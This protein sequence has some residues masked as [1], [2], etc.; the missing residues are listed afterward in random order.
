M[1]DNE[2]CICGIYLKKCLEGNLYLEMLMWEKKRDLKSWAHSSGELSG[3]LGN[4]AVIPLLIS[5]P[6]L[7][8]P[9]SY[10]SFHLK[11]PPELMTSFLFRWE[12]K[13]SQRRSRHPLLPDQSTDKFCTDVYCSPSFKVVS[14]DASVKNTGPHILILTPGLWSRSLFS[15]HLH[16]HSFYVIPTTY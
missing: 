15:H 1:C 9:I 5:F 8:V 16:P 7:G 12:K 6:A 4:P 14:D 10:L 3:L 13:S 2:P 11:F